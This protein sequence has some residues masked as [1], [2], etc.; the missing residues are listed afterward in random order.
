MVAT[1][2]PILT[3]SIRSTGTSAV[4]GNAQQAPNAGDRRV[5]VLLRV[6]GQQLVRHQRAVGLARDDIGESAAAVDPE[7][8]ATL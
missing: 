3:D 8:P 2:V 7:L 5:V 1:V 6:I 4:R